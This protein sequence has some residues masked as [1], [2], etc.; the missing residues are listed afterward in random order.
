[1]QYY[2]QFLSRLAQVSMH[3]NELSIPRDSTCAKQYRPCVPWLTHV[4]QALEQ[5][6]GT[7]YSQ[8]IFT[9]TRVVFVLLRVR[10]KGMNHS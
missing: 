9:Q 7:E 6:M 4:C 3:Q 1:M 5:T 10:Y 2:W 8:C